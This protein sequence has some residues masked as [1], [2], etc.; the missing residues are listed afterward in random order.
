MLGLKACVEALKDGAII[1][2]P[3]E[4]V[5]GLGCDPGNEQALQRL[6]RLK[7]RSPEQGLILIAAS[8][9]QLLP[10]ACVDQ[11]KQADQIRSGWPG[12]RT[13]VV[14][15]RRDVSK[16]LTGG[17]D[18]IAV[19]VTAHP[20]CIQLCQ[21]F[22]G[23]L[24]STS[25]NPAG[26]SPSRTPKQVEHYFG[27]RIAG[28]LEGSVGEQERPSEIRDGDSGEILRSGA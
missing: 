2:Y 16:S 19:R 12:H 28:V 18:T 26:E 8:Q 27:N 25:A 14:H 22:G 5:Y 15:A 11:A 23:A 1:A 21:A 6:I 9:S 4:A 20:D 13:W 10:F 3:T 7:Q 17:R 24:V